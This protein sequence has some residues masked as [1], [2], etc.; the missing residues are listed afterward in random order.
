[1]SDIYKL[2]DDIARFPGLPAEYIEKQLHQIPKAIVIDR[3]KYL[4]EQAQDKVILDIG[5]SGPLMEM[6]KK[7]AKSYHGCDIQGEWAE[8]FSPVNLDEAHQLPTVKGLELIIAGEIIEHLSNAGHFLDLCHAADVPVILTTPNAHSTNSSGYLKRGVENVNK[9]HVAWYSYHTL[10]V[11]IER[12]NFKLT[13][14]FW[15]NG[16]PIFAEGLIFR[17]EPIDG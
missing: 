1:M 2:Y 15:Y 9:E 10:K 16:K 4:V 12:H 3:V 7:V 13:E 11:L 14:W 5:A 8:D 17:L 6:L